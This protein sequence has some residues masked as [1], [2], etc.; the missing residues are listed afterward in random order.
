MKS[1]ELRIGNLYYYLVQDSLD[2]RERWIEPSIIDVHDLLYLDTFPDDP[3]F[4]PM[5]ITEELLI[6]FGFERISNPNMT[7]T[8]KWVKNSEN[9]FIQSMDNPAQFYLNRTSIKIN[10][11]HQI[12]NLYHSITGEELPTAHFKLPTA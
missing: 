6:G 5:P 1:N 2:D 12:Q 10:Y 8:W 11:A 7:A 3:D 9:W 4:H